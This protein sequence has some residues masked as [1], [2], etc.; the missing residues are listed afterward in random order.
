MSQFKQYGYKC[1]EEFIADRDFPM[2]QEQ[3]VQWFL[4]ETGSKPTAGQIHIM[5]PDSGEA[6]QDEL[7]RIY[8]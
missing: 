6:I 5:R 7:E 2:N 1:A 4:E 8:G 3:L